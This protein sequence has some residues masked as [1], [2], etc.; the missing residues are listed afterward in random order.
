M[1]KYSPIYKYLKQQKKLDKKI[2]KLHWKLEALKYRRRDLQKP[3]WGGDLDPEL[4]K[5]FFKHYCIKLQ[6]QGQST[7]SIYTVI[8]ILL[9]FE[10]T[11][12]QRPFWK[13]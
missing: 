1:S 8:D 4:Y 3:F 12:A 11:P 7:H 13:A 2:N 6:H 10:S 5:D 9:D